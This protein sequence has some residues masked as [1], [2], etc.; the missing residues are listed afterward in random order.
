[1]KAS[2]AINLVTS[3]TGAA[4]AACSKVATAPALSPC[5]SWVEWLE[6][7]LRLRPPPF[8]GALLPRRQLHQLVEVGARGVDVPSLL[9]PQRC[10]PK[11]LGILRL[12]PD[13]FEARCRDVEGCR[14]PAPTTNVLTDPRMSPTLGPSLG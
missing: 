5:S 13:A 12:F 8:L 9:R 7:M 11:G 4:V 3:V 6:A 1:M 14:S 10:L 2:V